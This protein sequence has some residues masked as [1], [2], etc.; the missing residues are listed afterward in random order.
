MNKD[1]QMTRLKYDPRGL[2]TAVPQI[3]LSWDLFKFWKILLLLLFL[4]TVFDNS[5]YFCLSVVYLS[6]FTNFF[7]FDCQCVRCMN[8]C[9]CT[10]M[11]TTC[12]HAHITTHMWFSE[13]NMG[14]S[15]CFLPWLRHTLFLLVAVC[16]RLSI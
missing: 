9:V 16:M 10:S 6:M 1:A 5:I 2:L 11:Y 14:V 13:D 12:R 7:I 4:W 15:P 8:M 3:L